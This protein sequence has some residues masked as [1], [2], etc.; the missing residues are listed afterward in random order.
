[1]EKI[2]TIGGGTGS[3]VLLSGLKNFP[4]ELSAIVSMA[5]DGGSTGILRDEMGVLPPGDIRQCLV[6]LSGSSLRL[7]QLFNY[8]YYNGSLSGH[9][10]GNLFLSTLEKLTGS[11]EEAIVEAGKILDI[12]GQVI[13]VTLK[14]TKLIARLKDGKTIVGQYNIQTTDIMALDTIALKPKAIISVA[15]R[16]AIREADKIVICPG[17]LHTSI[18]PNLLVGGI[19]REIRRARARKIYV[20]NIMTEKGQTEGYTVADFII[21]L[22]DFLGKGIFDYVVYNK[23]KPLPLLMKRY[24]REGNELVEP[25]DLGQFKKIKFVKSDLLKPPEMKPV[26]GDKIVRSYV[27]HDSAKIAKIICKL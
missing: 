26:K 9:S 6:A 14:K 24:R 27:R 23:A 13:P 5:D 19:C 22:E 7:R 15:A 17:N 16:D 10:F 11:F 21:K 2:V 8:R 25:G 3:F 20:A 1:M 18:M 12:N 4:V